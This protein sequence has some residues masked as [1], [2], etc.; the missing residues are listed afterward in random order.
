MASRLTDAE[1]QRIVSY[2]KMLEQSGYRVDIKA[3]YQGKSPY[4]GGIM[5]WY[6]MN[7]NTSS[8]KK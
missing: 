8:G 3:N 1:A 5:H 6:E 2:G 4:D 7:K